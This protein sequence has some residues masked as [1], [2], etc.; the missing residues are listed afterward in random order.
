[1]SM[2]PLGSLDNLP[3]DKE[4]EE[5][6]NADVGNNKVF[7]GPSTGSKDCKSVED[8]DDGKEDETKVSGVRLGK[9][10]EWQS[11]PLNT[12]SLES[13]IKS[14]GGEANC[15]PCEQIGNGDNIGK[16]V[17]HV[18][19]TCGDSHEREKGDGSGDCN[20]VDWDTTL[21]AFAE[22]PWS[23]TNLCHSEEV[24]G[25]GVAKS[26][27]GRRGRRQDDSVDNMWETLDT[28][29]IDGNDPW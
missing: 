20:A 13:T 23:L 21:G 10:L 6:W 17:E 1:M 2:E 29:T 19:T 15:A 28:G 22:E 14:D 7:N 16:P 27:S 5:D 12:L 9:S 26:V 11:A 24:S 25:S 18:S 4:A 3:N 8:D